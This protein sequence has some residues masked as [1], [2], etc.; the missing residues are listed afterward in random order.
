[1]FSL[2]SSECT[3]GVFAAISRDIWPSLNIILLSAVFTTSRAAETSEIFFVLLQD[4]FSKEEHKLSGEGSKADNC[5]SA[6]A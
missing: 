2:K 1:M 5:S 4:Y 3:Q 6:A